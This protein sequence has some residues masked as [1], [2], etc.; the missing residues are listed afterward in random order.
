MNKLKILFISTTL[1]FFLVACGS[2]NP[3]E[4]E[5]NKEENDALQTEEE[6]I[7]QENLNKNETNNLEEDAANDEIVEEA[8]KIE[9]RINEETWTVDP[10]DDADE[11]VALLTIDD[12]PDQYA[13]EM[14]K[15][16]KELDAN[17]IFFVNGHFLETEEKQE[18]LQEIHEL[19][20]VIGNHT[21]THK[22]LQELTEE[23]QKD[24]IIRVNDLVEDII[25]ERP[26]FFRAPFGV[27]TDYA[28]EVIAEENM[29]RMNWTYGYDY[30]EPYQNKETL[31]E[32]MIT[33]KGP[34]VDEDD[35]LLKPGAN[36][37]MHDREWTAA[38]L[39]D[40]VT[41]LREKGY[42]MVDPIS[43]E[44]TDDK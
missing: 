16:L 44:T 33:G 13:L 19:G 31:V 18:I 5:N 27:Y 28:K 11:K 1:L 15:T 37:L 29:I 43:I 7:P 41:G 20:F 38:G 12:A 10:I 40:I 25:G 39:Q 3:E 26:K 2:G 17:A 9:Y 32:A 4:I 8:P 23:E 24:E 36:L 14:A 30:F 21:Y 42:E 35:S 22:N 34:E 6:K